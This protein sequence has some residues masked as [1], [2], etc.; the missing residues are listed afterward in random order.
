M[1]VLVE[2]RRCGE[3]AL[4][5]HAAPNPLR[6]DP[7]GSWRLV[8]QRHE[9]PFSAVTSATVDATQP[10]S[11]AV[12]ADPVERWADGVA[13]SMRFTEVEHT[14]E[15]SGVCDRCR[16]DVTAHTPAEQHA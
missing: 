8:R 16:V 1:L 6:A 11:A 4:P 3:H 14:V 10:D 7:P 9:S 13:E 12:D 15:L 2:D 5:G